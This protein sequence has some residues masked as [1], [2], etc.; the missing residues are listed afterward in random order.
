MLAPIL[1]VFGASNGAMDVA[2]N[3]HGVAV[4]ENL[5]RPGHVVLSRRLERRD[6][7]HRSRRHRLRPLR[8]GDRERRTLLFTAAGRIDSPG[9][10]LAAAFTLGYTGFIVGP[11]VIGALSDQA[12]LPQ[13]L[14]LLILALITVSVLGGKPSA[15]AMRG[16]PPP[17]RLRPSRSSRDLAAGAG[18]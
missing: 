16:R 2:M 14:A 1:F 5:R 8:T 12:G 11:P 6:R 4:Q 17:Q 15:A 13:T 9:P 7:T 3:A 10:S 18:L